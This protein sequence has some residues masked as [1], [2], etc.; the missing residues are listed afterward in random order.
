M[1][2][3][4][5]PWWLGCFLAS[6][7]RRLGMDP[8]RTVAPHVREGDTVLEP[9][10][11]MGFF[12]GALARRVGS[13]G[14]VV[15][16]DIQPRMLAG[17]RRR[18]ARRDLGARVEA[19]LAGPESMGLADLE[20]RVDFVLAFAVVHEFPD[21][22][23]FFAQAAKAMKPGA[24]LLLAE[25]KGHVDAAQFQAELEAA[26]REGLEAEAGPDLRRSWTA[27]LRREG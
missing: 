11:G 9:G 26:R 2:H 8:D 15:A 12:T 7:L 13:S 5:C 10:P 25:P 3:G 19:R 18:M 22:G 16:V 6:P 17:L 27:L 23:G 20:G 14:R 21:P 4:V 1:A 24:R